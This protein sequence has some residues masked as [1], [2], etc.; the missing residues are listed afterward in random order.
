M[1]RQVYM[2]QQA[3]TVNQIISDIYTRESRR[4]FATLVRLLGDFNLAEEALQDAFSAALTQWPE[5]GIPDQPSAW[6]VS[7][8]RFKALDQARR[9]TRHDQLLQEVAQLTDDDDVDAEYMAIEDD[10]LR[11]IFT[12][13]HPAIA[14]SV[15]VPLTLREVCGLSTE[16]I[17]SAYLVSPSTMAQRI[18][19]GKAKIKDAK[20]P[21]EIPT[22]SELPERLDAVLAVIYLVFNEGYSTSEGASLTRVDLIAEAIHLTRTL[23]SLLPDP[24]AQGL[25]ALMLLHESRREARTDVDGDIVLLEDQD[26]STWNAALIAEG[27]ALTQAAL[28][29]RRFGFYTLQAAISAVHAQSSSYDSTNWHQIVS[30]YDVLRQ[31]EG[32]PVI[33]LNYAIALSM[34]DG[35][36]AGIELIEAVIRDGKLKDYHLLYSAYGELLSRAA[37]PQ[38]A[39]AAFET[40][41][42]LTTQSPERRVIQSKIDVLR[43]I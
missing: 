34:R 24:E 27:V 38:A 43:N 18:V 20:I 3:N 9:R 7:T 23:I 22:L 10:Q 2:P 15:Q 39:I 25:L 31:I 26:R 35:P 37:Q 17:A 13:C 41:L 42:T 6:L 36:Q 11:L 4:V 1:G 28:R 14:P 33:E 5:T 8:G 29:S 19:R 21:Y 30:L 12:C 32:T 40:A 16:E